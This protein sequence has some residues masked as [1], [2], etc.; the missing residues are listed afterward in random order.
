M[1]ISIPLSPKLESLHSDWLRTESR[2]NLA[3][4][5]R[6]T[7][8]VETLIYVVY[9]DD[10]IAGLRSDRRTWVLLP[11]RSVRTVAFTLHE[12]DWLPAVRQ[13]SEDAR[14][15]LQGLG[16]VS[17]KVWPAGAEASLPTSQASV[18]GDWLVLSRTDDASPQHMVGISS[19][20]LIETSEP[21]ASMSSAS[22]VGR[23]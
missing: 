4:V 22:T 2:A 14:T 17:F 8:Q 21:T 18:Q 13:T 19:V 20:A 3:K 9:G 15:Y 10:F 5:V 12:A 23:S 7:G 6:N 16:S 1:T 11:S